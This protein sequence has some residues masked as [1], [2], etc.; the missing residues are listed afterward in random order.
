MAGGI[1]NAFCWTHATFTLP[2]RQ[3]QSDGPLIQP[4][5]GPLK[6]GHDPQQEQVYHGFYQVSPHC[7][8]G[9]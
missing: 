6:A 3:F 2:Y 9:T 4:G 7:G 1:F 8:T 5:V